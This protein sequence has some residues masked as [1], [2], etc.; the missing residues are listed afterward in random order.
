MFAGTADRHL[1]GSTSYS[2]FGVDARPLAS[3]AAIQYMPGGEQVPFWALSSLGGDRSI[4]GERQP[5][6]GFGQGRFLDRNLFSG[7]LELRTH[8][9]D[10]NLFSREVS[11]EAAPFVDAGRVFHG[12]A[13]S[14][15]SHLH[16]AGGVGF[17]AI[18]RPFIVGYVDVGYGEEGV[19]MFSGIKYPF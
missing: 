10:L 3:R 5:L 18:A 16:V 14:P 4:V 7:S 13:Q 19:A 11:F 15:V 6:R 12:S 17:R 2:V 9:F 1:L 8:V